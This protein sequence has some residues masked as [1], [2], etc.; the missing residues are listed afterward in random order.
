MLTAGQWSVS[1]WSGASIG[2]A[3]NWIPVRALQGHPVAV[4]PRMKLC[5]AVV[6]LASFEEQMSPA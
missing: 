2:F 6:P 3:T 5:E 4:S 1:L